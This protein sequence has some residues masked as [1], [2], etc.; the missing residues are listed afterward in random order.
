MKKKK[1]KEIRKEIKADIKETK[2]TTPFLKTIT[3]Q[4]FA[5]NLVIL[6]AFSAFSFFVIRSMKNM[7]LS[8]IDAAT[9]QAETIRT[10]GRLRDKTTSIQGYVQTILE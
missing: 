6:L 3:F 10:E 9:N 8:S 4:V 2:K 1:I 7:V 5:I